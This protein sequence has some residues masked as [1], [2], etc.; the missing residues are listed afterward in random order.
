VELFDLITTLLGVA[1]E[2]EVIEYILVLVVI[3]FSGKEDRIFY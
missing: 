2:A 1:R 3:L